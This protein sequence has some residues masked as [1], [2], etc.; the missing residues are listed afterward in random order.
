MIKLVIGKEAGGLL[1]MLRYAR[2]TTIRTLE[3]LTASQ[4][5]Q[6]FDADS[7]S[8]G[9]LLMHVAGVEVA[10]QAG[11]FEGRELNAEELAQWQKWL[12]LTPESQSPIGQPLDHYLHLLASIRE[13][14][15]RELLARDEEWLLRATPFGETE[16]NNYW[17]WFHVCEDEINHRGQIRW[18]RKRLIT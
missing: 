16:A 14:T 10:Y 6:R 11:T 12:D 3:G 9:A 1:D 4:L 7:N 5:D 8:I 13:R 15:E 17:K 2:Y 18:L